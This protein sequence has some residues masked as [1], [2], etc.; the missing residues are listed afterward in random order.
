MTP[1]LAAIITITVVITD[2]I[3]RALTAGMDTTSST[4]KAVLTTST[5]TPAETHSSVVMV[6]TT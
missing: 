6:M 3:S 1:L 5:A 4:P 2:A